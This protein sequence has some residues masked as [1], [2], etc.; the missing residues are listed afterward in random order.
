MRRYLG[1][2]SSRRASDVH[3]NLAFQIQPGQI[4]V[5][6]FWNTQ[7]VSHKHQRRLHARGQVNARAEMHVVSQRERMGLTIANQRNA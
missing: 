7:P 3:D 2:K 5:I 1:A 4:I 6:F